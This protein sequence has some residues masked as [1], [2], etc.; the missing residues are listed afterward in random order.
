MTARLRASLVHLLTASGAALALLALLASAS[1]DW[2]AMFMWLGLTL[3]VDGIDG[4][5]ARR[6]HVATVLPRFSGARLDLIVD[7]LTYVAIPAFALARAEILPEGFRL[8]AAI[9]ILLSSL[10]HVVDRDSK[11]EDGYFVGF[12]AI[13]NIV[14]LYLFCFHASGT[15]SLGC[16]PGVRRRHLRADPLC[17]SAARGALARPHSHRHRSVDLCRNRRG[18]Q[19]ISIAALG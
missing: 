11:T 2:Q 14:C 13:W 8:P 4:P 1:G 7:Y 19:S 17:A 6:A 18:S 16:D 15:V 10:F 3:V 9:A 12:P 5:L